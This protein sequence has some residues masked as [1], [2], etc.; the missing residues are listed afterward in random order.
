MVDYCL[1]EIVG[2][3][4]GRQASMNVMRSWASWVVSD[5]A[6]VAAQPIWES[7]GL[8]SVR[9]KIQQC[10]VDMEDVPGNEIPAG[11]RIG[12]QR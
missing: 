5:E 4:R 9:I 8:L 11:Y 7:G 12:G 10:G 3:G 6:E 2:A 1:V